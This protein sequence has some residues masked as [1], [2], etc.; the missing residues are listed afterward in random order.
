MQSDHRW[1]QAGDIRF[2]DNSI[3]E[4]LERCDRCNGERIVRC[5]V[6]DSGDIVGDV[7]YCP[8]FGLAN[9]CPGHRS[10]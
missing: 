8:M 6:G 1:N 4:W 10:G 7:R 9:P 2:P 3:V 5:D